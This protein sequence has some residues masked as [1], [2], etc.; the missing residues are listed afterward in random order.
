[1]NDDIDEA[2]ATPFELSDMGELEREQR[3]LENAGRLHWFHW[4]VVVAS[5]VLT[6]G[7]W[8][9]SRHQLAAKV[10]GQF[11]R[12]ATQVVNLVRERLERY[13]DALWAGVAL[14][15]SHNDKISMADWRAFSDGLRIG[16]R[17]PGIN[18][19]G[20]IYKVQPE[21]LPDFLARVHKEQ[22]N[23]EVYPKH[24]NSPLL[25]ITYVEP[26]AANLKAIGLD[27]AHES[28]RFMAALNARDTGMAQVTGPIVLVQ[29]AAKTPGFLFQ[30]PFYEATDA[31]QNFVGLVYAPFIVKN[32]MDGILSQSARQVGVRISDNGEGL[33]D[34]QELSA[35]GTAVATSHRKDWVQPVYGRNWTFTVWSTPSFD[36]ANSSAQPSLIL[37]G[38]L[39]LDTFLFLLFFMLARANQRALKFAGHMKQRYTENAHRLQ[40]TVNRL[41]VSNV[42]LEQFAYIASHDLQEPLRTLNNYT[43]LLKRELRDSDN[44]RIDDSLRFIDGAANRMRNL[45]SGLLAYSK[46]GQSREARRVDCNDLLTDVLA[47]VQGSVEQAGGVIKVDKLPM[48]TAYETDL[49]LLFQNIISNAVKFSRSGVSPEV[50]ITCEKVGAGWQFNIA[51]NGVG[52]ALEDQERIFKIFKRLH[53]QSEF[54]GSGIGL[55]NCKKIVSLHGGKLWV[56]SRLGEGSTFHFTIADISE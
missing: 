50:N 34:E 9:Y 38:G 2:G 19:I 37:A 14:I 15:E 52:V 17:Y 55:A 56:T 21:D 32:L 44:K 53:N 13:E 27:V 11:D 36:K 26:Q 24:Q 7:V 49:R 10:E 8:Q 48:I 4:A 3:L 28:N 43:M 39:L 1:M 18:G 46:V 30:V 54:D 33:Y 51:D 42:E 47:D 6:F 29:D 31:G 41:E 20:V 23:F 12:Q 35:A 5:L 45:V 22:P 16:E 40:S 25:P